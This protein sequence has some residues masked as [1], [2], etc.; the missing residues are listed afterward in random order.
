MKITRGDI[1][2]FL[3]FNIVGILNTLVDFGVFTLLTSFNLGIS[4]VAAHVISYT[5]GIVNSY[6]LNSSWTFRKE[7]RRTPR[8]TL[9]FLLVN[10]VSL[11][12]STFVLYCCENWL[13]IESALFAKV[14]ATGASLVVNF[15]G[16]KLFVFKA[17]NGGE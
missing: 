6:A 12:V 4:D 9:L 7:R 15:L 11:G 8:E 13:G 3:K 14:I 1:V 2:Q 10:L 5:C 17:A 16:N